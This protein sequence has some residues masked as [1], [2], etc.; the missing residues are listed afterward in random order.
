MAKKFLLLDQGFGLRLFLIMKD[1]VG[2]PM[3][4]K[5]PH[6]GIVG[7]LVYKKELR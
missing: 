5:D 3:P 2:V 7:G 4:Q 6:H 1:Y